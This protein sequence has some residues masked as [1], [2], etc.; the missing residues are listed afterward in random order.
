M[1]KTKITLLT[2]LS[3]FTLQ[4]FALDF[5]YSKHA[6]YGFESK[7]NEYAIYGTIASANNFWLGGNQFKTLN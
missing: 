6:W 5:V 1:Q 4:V 2:L 7:G 3:F